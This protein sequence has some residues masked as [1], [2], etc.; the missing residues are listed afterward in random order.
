MRAAASG[1]LCAEIAPRG[2]VGMAGDAAAEEWWEH[3]IAVKLDLVQTVLQ[4]SV[5]PDQDEGGGM[6]A[7]G[8]PTLPSGAAPEAASE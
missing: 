1:W 2:A 7:Q 4:D 6:S 8:R 3:Y 5:L